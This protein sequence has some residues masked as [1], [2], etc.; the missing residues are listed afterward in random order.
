MNV[1]SE[2]VT[3]RLINADA[4]EAELRGKYSRYDDMEQ[5]PEVVDAKRLIRRC[6][7]ELRATP[8]YDGGAVVV[9]Q[10]NEEVVRCP[11]C[12]HSE[13]RAGGWVCR[14]PRGMLMINDMSFCSEG[15]SIDT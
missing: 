3:P 7:A 9:V 10:R 8:T 14:N 1:Q 15:K 13:R 6:I 2:V 5:T 12:V 4:K 11:K